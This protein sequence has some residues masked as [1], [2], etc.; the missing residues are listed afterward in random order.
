LQIPVIPIMQ[1]AINM[2]DSKSSRFPTP[3]HYYCT[4]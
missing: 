1:I 3:S 2:R 4:I